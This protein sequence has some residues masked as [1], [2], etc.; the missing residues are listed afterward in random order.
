M[1]IF[2]IIY[3]IMCS[4]KYQVSNTFVAEL[5]RC[6]IRKQC[7]LVTQVNS[8]KSLHIIV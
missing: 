2:G 8:C 4:Q 7:F 6:N 3:M 5:F 1:F